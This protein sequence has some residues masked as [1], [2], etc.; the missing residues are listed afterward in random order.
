MAGFSAAELSNIGFSGAKLKDANFTARELK[1]AGLK[2]ALVFTLLE[3]KG[4]LTVLELYHEEGFFLGDLRD[5]G[6][7]VQELI[8]GG[9]KASASELFE[10]GYTTKDMRAG[11]Y[12]PSDAEALT[13]H[14]F[15]HVHESILPCA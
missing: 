8:A 3:L 2:P 10:A 5:G 15:S 6:Y 14:A 9:V 1:N 11:G 4:Q 7:K 13:G 12:E